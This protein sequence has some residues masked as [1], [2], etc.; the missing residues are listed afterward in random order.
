MRFRGAET[1]CERFHKSWPS[2]AYIGNRLL[3]RRQRDHTSSILKYTFF[4]WL[5]VFRRDFF[6]R[7]TI[8]PTI[9]RSTMRLRSDEGFCYHIVP[10]MVTHVEIPTRLEVIQ[11]KEALNSIPIT[12]AGC[13]PLKTSRDQHLALHVTVNLASEHVI[14]WL[15]LQN[16]MQ[17]DANDFNS[18]NLIL[19]PPAALLSKPSAA[20]FSS[21]TEYLPR[22]NAIGA[23]LTRLPPHH[24]QSL[25]IT[26]QILI[27]TTSSL[28]HHDSHLHSSLSPYA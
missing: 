13:C 19:Q 11:I 16:V 7:H 1:D 26:S 22:P 10:A 12:T 9:E 15:I 25:F 28:F 18:P 2:S 27:L 20:L 14:M 4:A 5:A 23:R 3:G 8:P 17:C 24:R 6:C 21:R